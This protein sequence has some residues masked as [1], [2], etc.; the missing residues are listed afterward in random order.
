MAFLKSPA[1]VLLLL[2]LLLHVARCTH[3]IVG[4]LEKDCLHFRVDKNNIIVG[5]YEIIDKNA[6]CLMYIVNRNDK[7]KEKLFKSERVQDKFEIKVTKP[8]A[9]SFCYANHKKTEITVMFTLRV[10]ESHDAADAELGTA[11]DVQKISNEASQL[12]EQFFEVFEEQEKMME[13][14]D[15]Y[16]QFNEKMNSKLILWSEVQIILLILLTLIHIFYIKSFF[17][18]KTIV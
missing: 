1:V 13:T 18:I 5:S 12:Y 11:D 9:Y 15:L 6:L 3:F 4:P 2:V 16:K 14:A 7:K 8:G 10:K 17:E